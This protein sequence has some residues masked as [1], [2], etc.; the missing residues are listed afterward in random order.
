MLRNHCVQRLSMAAERDA[1]ERTQKKRNARKH[2]K[3]EAKDLLLKI[4]RA[5]PD[6]CPLY[7]EKIT[8]NIFTQYMN[9]RKKKV[10]QRVAGTNEWT[11]VTTYL[12]KSSY[13]GM[14][15]ALV[16]LHCIM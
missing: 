15:S 7:F 4:D 14:K 2:F 5:N 8:F 16:Y 9:T 3:D 11:E 6:S 10:K 1:N 13:D 12:S